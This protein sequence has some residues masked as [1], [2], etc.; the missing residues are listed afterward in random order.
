MSTVSQT[1]NSV[2]KNRNEPELPMALRMLL[3]VCTCTFFF[4]LG[5]M[6]FLADQA[7]SKE[8]QEILRAIGD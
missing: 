3:L 4:V 8:A 5:W 7:N 2:L 6:S 1:I